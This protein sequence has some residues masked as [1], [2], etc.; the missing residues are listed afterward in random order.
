MTF[1]LFLRF[2]PQKM[3]QVPVMLG[4]Y[5]MR[6]GKLTSLF[7]NLP[8]K[9]AYEGYFQRALED[10]LS[11]QSNK[12]NIYPQKEKIPKNCHSFTINTNIIECN[13]VPEF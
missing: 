12:M 6:R 4:V 2:L 11:G 10:A 5:W 13:V 3:S 7:F 1:G 9:E 8:T